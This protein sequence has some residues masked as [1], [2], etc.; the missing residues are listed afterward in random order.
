MAIDMQS[1]AWRGLTKNCIL[2]Y[3]ATLW[4]MSSGFCCTGAEILEQNGFRNR[5]WAESLFRVAAE[6]HVFAN[7]NLP[8]G[9]P[10]E[11]V[12]PL[13]T[14]EIVAY[15]CLA[16]DIL[17]AAFY[18]RLINEQR[19]YD[20]DFSSRSAQKSYFRTLKIAKRK[21]REQ[22]QKYL[23]LA[24]SD[25]IPQQFQRAYEVDTPQSRSNLQR[26]VWLALD[27]LPIVYELNPRD[28]DATDKSRL[29]GLWRKYAHLFTS[30]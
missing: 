1:I 23:K 22:K 4:E 18:E 26:S 10:F 8:S 14:D 2:E 15:L 25:K 21:F 3:F 6:Q 9:L 17:E 28:K 30:I 12:Q 5:A 19:Q 13:I 7:C 11:A 24:Y 16:D 20:H 27:L 29:M